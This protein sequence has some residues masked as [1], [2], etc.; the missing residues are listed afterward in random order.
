MNKSHQ[1]FEL[2]RRKC[3]QIGS[4]DHFSCIK[5]EKNVSGF[6]YSDWVAHVMISVLTIFAL[7]M[8]H[9]SSC[10]EHCLQNPLCLQGRRIVQACLSKHKVQASSFT[11]SRFKSSNFM[12]LKIIISNHFLE[13][14][15]YFI[16]RSIDRLTYRG[17]MTFLSSER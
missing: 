10:L 1:R 14:I 11:V 6:E 7:H 2:H 4:R 13:V 8:G 17:R 15:S 16:V 9:V 5:M 3:L 12:C